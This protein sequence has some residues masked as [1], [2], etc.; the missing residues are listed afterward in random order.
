MSTCGDHNSRDQ[1]KADDE[2]LDFDVLD[3]VPFVDELEESLVS[4]DLAGADDDDKQVTAFWGDLI[5]TSGDVW[6]LN[7]R[8]RI[9][10]SSIDFLISE[11]IPESIAMGVREALESYLR[12]LM[13]KRSATTV[14]M[15]HHVVTKL[16]REPDILANFGAAGSRL[17]ATIYERMAANGVQLPTI[18]QHASTFRKFYVWGAAR[19]EQKGWKGFDFQ[20]AVQ[21]AGMTIKSPKPGRA[22][23]SFDPEEG[24]LSSQEYLD[25]R[26]AILAAADDPA[27][28]VA[29][30]VAAALMLALGVN[31]ESLRE[32]H[33]C[34]LIRPRHAGDPY[35]LRVPRIKKPGQRRRR[36]AFCERLLIPA[37]GLLVERLIELNWTIAPPEPSLD[38]ALGR[39]LFRRDLPSTRRLALGY[40]AEALL[41]RHTY[42]GQLLDELVKERHLTNDIGLPLRLTPRRLR[43]SFLSREVAKKTRV[44]VLATMMDHS[45]HRSL[46]S[47]FNARLDI[48][49]RLDDALGQR[50]A[51]LARIMLGE[52]QAADWHQLPGMP[53]DS[54]ADLG[55]RAAPFACVRCPLFRPRSASRLRAMA[56]VLSDTARRMQADGQ[57]EEQTGPLHDLAA[58]AVAAAWRCEHP[59]TLA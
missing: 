52:E 25:V 41:L 29:K 48:V 31:P 51:P 43:Y 36:D 30:V 1:R 22:V 38:E 21:L 34:D 39:P 3:S 13:R 9:R 32:I 8:R 28:D 59:R 53:E 16:L 47:Y 11:Q 20:T 10:F 33:E 42:F 56:G 5:D 6:Q 4:E 45:D 50:L 19:A 15:A 26:D 23:L 27:A 7:W 57:P 35:V 54:A 37:F 12:M 58:A 17:I 46:L 40:D 14:Y 49:T 18:R 2:I 24:P 44:E 55:L